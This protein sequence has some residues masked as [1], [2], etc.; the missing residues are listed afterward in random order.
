[1]RAG[2]LSFFF[3]LGGGRG[4]FAGGGEL[5]TDLIVRGRVLAHRVAPVIAHLVFFGGEVR[6]LIVVNRRVIL[7]KSIRCADDDFDGAGECAAES[8]FP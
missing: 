7:S 6:R 5:R 2:R 4:G 1:M 3:P 8:R